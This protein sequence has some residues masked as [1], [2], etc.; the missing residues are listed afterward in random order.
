[1]GEWIWVIILLF[2]LFRLL[3]LAGKKKEKGEEKRTSPR[4]G[5]RPV[6]PPRRMDA[7]SL[8]DFLEQLRRQAEPSSRRRPPPPRPSSPRPPAERRIKPMENRPETASEKPEPG[9][10]FTD[11]TPPEVEV[12]KLDEAMAEARKENAPAPP[13]IL[14]YSSHPVLQGIIFSEI[15]GAPKG[16]RSDSGLPSDF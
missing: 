8:S 3:S 4:T 13:S 1:M 14:S 10:A 12:P 16:L 7:S 5:R 11:F 15:I 9:E 6:P 2:G